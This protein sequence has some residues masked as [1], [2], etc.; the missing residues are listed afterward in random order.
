MPFRSR[1]PIFYRLI[2]ELPTPAG[3]TELNR[4]STGDVARGNAVIEP[5]RSAKTELLVNGSPQH[6]E[7]LKHGLWLREEHAD[8]PS[9]AMASQR[10]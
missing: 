6:Q 5:N 7:H 10:P 1:I 2:Q 9:K 4:P 8:L 3:I